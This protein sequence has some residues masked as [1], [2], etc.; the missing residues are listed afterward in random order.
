MSTNS[1]KDV[2][3]DPVVL[4]NKH[5]MMTHK[6]DKLCDF[7]MRKCHECERGDYDMI[8]SLIKKEQIVETKC[9]EEFLN[10]IIAKLEKTDLGKNATNIYQLIS[11]RLLMRVMKIRKERHDISEGKQKK[12]DTKSEKHGMKLNLETVQYECKCNEECHS[13]RLVE[14]VFRHINYP[15]K[16]VKDTLRHLGKQ[17]AKIKQQQLEELI[18]NDKILTYIDTCCP[19]VGALICL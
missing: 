3:T 18:G 16:A 4:C 6:C 13:C 5:K 15:S 11:V 7:W 19:A 12:E 14:N 10:E 9:D 1:S 2:K 17:C 8:K